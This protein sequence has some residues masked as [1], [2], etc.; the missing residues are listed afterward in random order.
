MISEQED[1]Q[2][3][4]SFRGPGVLNSTYEEENFSVPKETKSAPI[5]IYPNPAGENLNLIFT[6][7]FTGKYSLVLLDINGKTVLQKTGI[8]YAGSTSTVLDI[9]TLN[10]GIYILQFII[11]EKKFTSKIIKL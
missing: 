6:E 3:L 8:K 1:S 7:I 9:K 5:I 4:M 11:P 2:P 10:K